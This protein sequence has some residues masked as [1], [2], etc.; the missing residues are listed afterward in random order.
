MFI[1][2]NSDIHR[3]YNSYLLLT[4]SIQLLSLT[5]WGI[6]NVEKIKKR[7]FTSAQSP[8]R[9]VAM[10]ESN[11][12]SSSSS[13]ANKPKFTLFPKLPIE[14]RLKIWK[15]SYEPRI[16][17]LRTTKKW[18]T[19]RYDFF[20]PKFPAVLHVNKEARV[21]SLKD[22]KMSFKHRQ[23]R[24][25]IL[26]NFSIDTLHIRDRFSDQ[27]SYWRDISNTTK[28]LPDREKVQKLSV[29]FGAFQFVLGDDDYSRPPDILLFPA[30]KEVTI[31]SL[32]NGEAD[33]EQHGEFYLKSHLGECVP[34]SGASSC[35]PKNSNLT[36]IPENGSHGAQ[37]ISNIT[38]S[39]FSSEKKT[40]W[41]TFCITSAVA[42][43]KVQNGKNQAST[44]EVSA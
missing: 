34:S 11:S 16:I 23:C 37:P 27:Y 30:L 9:S 28:I 22:Y 1:H 10:E 33:I 2:R 29:T 44:T 39:F 36:L 3:F 21:E 12:A 18:R 19:K 17:E 15:E 38:E 42:N 7:T 35:F 6:F 41:T 32:I 4:A 14:L 26:F 31:C 24:R 13:D 40:L 5:V 20:I 25:P 8:S 43:G